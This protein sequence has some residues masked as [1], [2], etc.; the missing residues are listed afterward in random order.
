MMPILRNYQ[1]SIDSD[2]QAFISSDEQRGQVYSPTGSGKTVCFIHTINQYAGLVSMFG[3]Q[4]Q[5][6]IL[7]VHPRIALSQDQLSRFKQSLPSNTFHYTSFHSG[8]HITGNGIGNAEGNTTNANDVNKYASLNPTKHQIVFSS[9]DSVYKLDQIEWDLIIC[10]EA[11]NLANNSKF[12]GYAENLNG[13]KILFY[14]ATP[15]WSQVFGTEE[16][17]DN[18]NSMSN[19]SVY[20]HPIHQLAPMS[21]IKEGYI[22][23]PLVH[24][25]D[26]KI[27]EETGDEVDPTEAVISA[28]KYQQPLATK[29]GME[30]HQMLVATSG[31][32]DIIKLNEDF[33]TIKNEL[34]DVT[35]ITI[36][37]EGKEEGSGV[38]INGRQSTKDRSEALENLTGNVIVCHYDTLAEGIDIPT[39]T[40]AF[41]MRSLTKTKLIQTLGR[42]CRPFKNDLDKDGNPLFVRFQESANDVR[43]KQYSVITLLMVNG[44]LPGSGNVKTLEDITEAFASGGY[45]D[46]STFVGLEES[47]A[48]S[49]SSTTDEVEDKENN[50][51]R[52]KNC[53]HR[54]FFDAIN[55]SEMWKDHLAF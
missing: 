25:Q 1:K 48:N 9:Y 22:L 29:N 3:S 52:I 43:R 44:E 26:L 55:K 47:E 8:R 4:K 14:T 19:V 51:G 28:F 42:P 7:V 21:L 34:G 50:M 41:I 31:R 5:L 36:M 17:I 11:H 32:T 6:R 10:D 46:L 12:K 18:D 33:Y 53:E 40:G 45:E 27:E 16:I 23:P 35:L 20:G 54:I 15:V 24:F 37:S 30:Y 39:L 49:N 13:R 38:W 2:V